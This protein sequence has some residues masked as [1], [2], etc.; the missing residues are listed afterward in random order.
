MD[1]DSWEEMLSLNTI[2]SSN[3]LSGV[4]ISII[5]VSLIL[6]TL[7]VL[8]VWTVASTLSEMNCRE[9]VISRGVLYMYGERLSIT[10]NTTGC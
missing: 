3:V 2:T 7:A 4:I 6:A 1:N 10:D 8:T 5:A 9:E